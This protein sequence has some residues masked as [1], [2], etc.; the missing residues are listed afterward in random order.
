VHFLPA[1]H[2][3]LTSFSALATVDE[4]ALEAMPVRRLEES[5][6]QAEHKMWRYWCHHGEN[7]CPHSYRFLNHG[8]GTCSCAFFSG[9]WK[10]DAGY[11][12]PGIE[13]DAADIIFET[14]QKSQEGVPFDPRVYCADKLRGRC[15]GGSTGLW[16]QMAGRC[17]CGFGRSTSDLVTRNTVFDMT[18]SSGEGMSSDPGAYCVKKLKGRCRAG[19][20]ILRN[21]RSGTCFCGSG[22][23]SRDLATRD[24]NRIPPFLLP[25]LDS[26]IMSCWKSVCPDGSAQWVP[27]TRSCFCG[28]SR[29]AVDL[30]PREEQVES[31]LPLEPERRCFD[32]MANACKNGTV[33]LWNK[34]QRCCYC[35]P[36]SN[37]T[38][39]TAG[40]TTADILTSR[41][42]PS[43]LKFPTGIINSDWTAIQGILVLL[44]GRLKTQTDLHQ[45]C[46]GEKNPL[47]YGFKLDV[48]RKLCTPEITVPVA[49]AEVVKTEQ[50]IYSAL[51]IDTVLA[52]YNNDFA[53]ACKDA[54]RPG[55]IPASLD[56]MFIL[57]Q[58][59]KM[60]Q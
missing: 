33:G 18:Q 16:N 35:G 41:L 29:S 20:P 36:A 25:P 4:K 17:F 3:L 39:S 57:S 50:K 53:R 30:E 10:R 26:R 32:T 1:N 40:P 31:D 47:V 60:G 5:V 48:F 46:T 52:R 51:W 13:P 55:E 54:K 34:D 6:T 59:C 19:A 42:L 14:T 38:L 21:P 43:P 37:M 24:D 23:L 45:I 22:K 27:R 12:A 15:Q 2:T 58:L 11:D 7:V 56:E 44:D 8:D 49:T 9:S 28:S